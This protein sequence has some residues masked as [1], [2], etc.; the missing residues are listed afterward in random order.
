[1]DLMTLIS[2]CAQF[3]LASRHPQNN[4]PGLHIASQFVAGVIEGLRAN[5]FPAYAEMIALGNDLAN[6]VKPEEEPH[7]RP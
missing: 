5:G 4:G 1:M 6:D 7:D 2:L 3:Q